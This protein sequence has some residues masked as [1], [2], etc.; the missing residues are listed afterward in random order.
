MHGLINLIYYRNVH[1]ATNIKDYIEEYDGTLHGYEF[2]WNKTSKI[3]K[4]WQEE[5][6]GSFKCINKENFLDFIRQ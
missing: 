4:L 3:P 1:H 5:Y 2:K 6:G